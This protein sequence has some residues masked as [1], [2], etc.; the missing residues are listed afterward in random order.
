MLHRYH[1]YLP[2]TLP[3][4]H[5][6]RNTRPVSRLVQGNHAVHQG[7]TSEFV[8]KIG[9]ED[10]FPSNHVYKE[11]IYMTQDVGNVS[12]PKF[13]DPRY[14]SIQLTIRNATNAHL[15]CCGVGGPSFH[16]PT[17]SVMTA[18]WMLTRRFLV[19]RTPSLVSRWQGTI[20]LIGTECVSSELNGVQ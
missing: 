19:G 20:P 4:H 11:S 13:I 18:E 12:Y 9:S 7:L 16:R 15:P 5:Q 14:A 8:F 1:V 6:Q 17:I 3:C 2:T 10:S